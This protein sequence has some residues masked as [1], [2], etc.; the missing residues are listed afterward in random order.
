M[1]MDK[2]RRTKLPAISEQMKAWSA[3]LAAEIADWPN[4]NT[5]SFFGFTALYRRDKL[6][7]LLPRTRA[8]ETANSLV[9][10]LEAPARQLLARLRSDSRVGSAVMKKARWFTFEIAT[11]AD[12][13]DALDWLGRGY[14]AAG[15][16]KKLS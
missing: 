15:K 14:D 13:R 6:F 2:S 12:L 16:R 4:V 7:G 9:F 8:M 5:R 3:A 11:D 10:K 1:K